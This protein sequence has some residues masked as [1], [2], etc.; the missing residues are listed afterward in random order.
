MDDEIE[1]VSMTMPAG[2]LE[3]LDEVVSEWDYASRSEVFRDALRGFLTEHRWQE[4]LSGVQRGSVSVV[5][6]HDAGDVNDE[7]TDVQHD[8]HDGI[9]AVQHVHLSEHLCM[10]TL[11]VD[12]PGDEIRDL[13]NRIKSLKGV[14]QVKLALV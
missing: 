3:E 11:V 4:D 6:D 2:L 7:L 1:R 8:F 5:Y 12:A 10:E 9:V 13:V 14:N